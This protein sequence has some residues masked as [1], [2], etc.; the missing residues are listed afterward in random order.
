VNEEKRYAHYHKNAVNMHAKRCQW[1][2]VCM[3]GLPE[4][5]PRVQHANLT[6]DA[7]RKHHL[8]VCMRPEGPDNPF[9]IVMGQAYTRS[10]LDCK[11]SKDLERVDCMAAVDAENASSE[12]ER[13][14][15]AIR[16]IKK[17]GK[18]LKGKEH[19]GVYPE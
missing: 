18:P 5:D 12:I 8:E 10:Y 1:P 19:Y 6:N 4:D 14:L 17:R 15:A 3:Y 9:K 7:S 13:H 11:C 2:D 16:K